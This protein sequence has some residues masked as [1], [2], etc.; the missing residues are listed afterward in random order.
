MLA[1]CDGFLLNKM[2]RIEPLILEYRD[3][4]KAQS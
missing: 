3:Y 1:G 2:V 4:I